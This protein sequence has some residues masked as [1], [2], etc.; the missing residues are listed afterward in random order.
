[1]QSKMR[2]RVLIW[3]AVVS[4]AILVLTP[5]CV[6]VLG[7]WRTRGSLDGFLAEAEGRG[8]FFFYLTFAY[9]IHVPVA[10]FVWL[11]VH[12]ARKRT[13]QTVLF[14]YLVI[15]TGMGVS[16]IYVYSWFRSRSFPLVRHVPAL[17]YVFV[18]LPLLSYSLVSS[19]RTSRNKYRLAR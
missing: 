9:A 5:V 3:T 17:L 16:A 12:A 15:L 4:T 1:M 7:F 18:V 2:S 14:M 8:F 13:L 19:F 6:P 11:F 10:A